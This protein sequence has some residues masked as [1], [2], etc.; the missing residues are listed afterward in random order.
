MGILAA[1]AATAA[2]RRRG[3][4]FRS[5]GPTV[6]GIRAARQGGCAGG[7]PQQARDTH[8]L[9]RPSRHP[10]QP[11]DVL[12]QAPSLSSQRRSQPCS[13]ARRSTDP[14]YV[15]L[16]LIGEVVLEDVGDAIHVDP[17]ACDVGGHQ[18]GNLP[19][20]SHSSPGCAYLALLPRIAAASIPTCAS[21]FTNRFAVSV[22]EH[23]PTADV[24]VR[25]SRPSRRRLSAF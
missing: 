9:R 7:G 2:T 4:A 14:V 16:R 23:D 5:F 12:Q 8:A 21:C 15:A 18:D 22:R 6:S 1:P 13:P 19:L 11:L 10:G 25:I 20:G 24:C 3:R 17:S